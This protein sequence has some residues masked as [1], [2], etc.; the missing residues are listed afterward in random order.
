MVARNT[1]INNQ[2]IRRNIEDGSLKTRK[3]FSLSLKKKREIS[4]RIDTTSRSGNI[5][6]FE[7][8]RSDRW[9]TATT[10]ILQ[11]WMADAES[12]P[13]LFTTPADTVARVSK[14]KTGSRDFQW[15]L[16]QQ[17][18]YFQWHA[19]NSVKLYRYRPSSQFSFCIKNYVTVS[20]QLLFHQLWN[21]KTSKYFPLISCEYEATIEE[22]FFIFFVTLFNNWKLSSFSPYNIFFQAAREINTNNVKSYRK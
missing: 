13:H 17:P 2:K 5:H 6:N 18:M 15:T 9:P 11:R 7:H 1:A 16:D 20:V 22:C 4:F 3:S 21:W 14:E 10:G 19:L 8:F 12:S